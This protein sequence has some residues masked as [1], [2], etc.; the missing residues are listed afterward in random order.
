MPAVHRSEVIYPQP[1]TYYSTQVRKVM[2]ATG[3][4]HD[5]RESGADRS[6]A[7]ETC[8]KSMLWHQIEPLTTVEEGTVTTCLQCLVVDNGVA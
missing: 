1:Y 4:V 8:C 6:H 3:I 7:R 2:D 5:T